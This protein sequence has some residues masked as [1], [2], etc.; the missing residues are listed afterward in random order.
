MKRT[1]QKRVNNKFK[2][3][4]MNERLDNLGLPLPPRKPEIKKPLLW[5]AIKPQND[6]VNDIYL[7]NETGNTI[8]NVI[9]NTGGFQTLDD[10]M[11][12]ISGPDIEYKKIVNNDAVKVEEYDKLHDSDY[13]L[14]ISIKVKLNGKWSDF[15]TSTAKGGFKEEVLLWNF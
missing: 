3:L 5:I 10:D 9:A 12:C 11:L 14:E 7:V 6:F 1:S 8:E 4:P 13:A 15:K 2:W